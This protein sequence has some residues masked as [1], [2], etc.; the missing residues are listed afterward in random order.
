M[1]SYYSGNPTGEFLVP[2]TNHWWLRG[3]GLF[4]TLK[5]ENGAI[6]FLDQHLARLVKSSKELLF[7]PVNINEI[8]ARV[9]EV[10][11]RTSGVERG[12]LRITLFPDSHFLISHEEAPLRT[13]P[14]KLLLAQKRRYSN[15]YLT[16]RKSLSYGEASFSARLANQHGCDDLLF[17]NERDEIVETGMANLL[18]EERGIFYTPPLSSGC[19]PGIVRSVLLNWF[20]EVQEKVLTLED[21]S[22]A[23]GLYIISSLREI[24]L[25]SE[26]HR[27]DSDQSD[28]QKFQISATAEK[29]R[30][31]YLINSRSV[32]KRN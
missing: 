15:S 7:E 24:D 5:T 19:L 14:Q 4:E 8:K 9:Q 26:L 3:D 22:R 1:N 20:S 2:S 29:L 10:V 25:V 6:F 32:P 18:V 21:L 23:S 16:G 27:H 12:R 17:L 28:V 11:E 31:D 13:R 30:G